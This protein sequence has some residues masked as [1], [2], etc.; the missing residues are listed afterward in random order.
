[1]GL[2]NFK[3]PSTEEIDA[4]PGDKFL[5]AASALTLYPRPPREAL[6]GEG[7]H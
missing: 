2:P 3:F 7:G 5:V 6:E 4:V 1:M